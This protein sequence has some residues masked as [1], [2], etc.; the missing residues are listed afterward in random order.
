MERYLS[1]PA[2]EESYY[3]LTGQRKKLPQIYERFLQGE[4]QKAQKI[5]RQFLFY[6]GRGMANLISSFDPDIIVIG[7][8]VSNLPLL[9]TEGVE[10]VRQQVFDEALSTPI[11]PNQLGD[12]SGIYGAA[13]I[14]E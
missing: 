3:Q 1:G 13:L 11:V 14:A 9:Y 12:S 6:F 4:D 2:V 7:G 5:I 10:Q 8:G